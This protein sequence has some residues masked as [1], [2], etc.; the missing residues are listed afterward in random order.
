MANHPGYSARKP[1]TAPSP[2][3]TP[4]GDER[5]CASRRPF[6]VSPPAA[7]LLA[8]VLICVLTAAALTPGAAAQVN[9][10]GRAPI[11]SGRVTLTASDEMMV[12]AAGARVILTCASEP[13]SRIEI[14]DEDGAFRFEQV[15][16][17]E[18]A[19][20]TELQGFAAAAAAIE[21]APAD[22]RF[23]LQAKPLYTSVTVRADAFRA[24]RPA[25][26]QPAQKQARPARR[27]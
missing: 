9:G 19:L 22:I 27:D 7:R 17:S 6:I 25:R 11:I 2:E 21:I 3:P 15:P 13:R 14:A 24:C 12:P 23:H 20:S 4:T 1:A 8:E 26:R 16:Q 5:V 10:Q 18:C